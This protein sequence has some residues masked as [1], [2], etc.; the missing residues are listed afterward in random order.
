[1]A[2]MRELEAQRGCEALTEVS[3]V[4]SRPHGLSPAPCSVSLLNGMTTLTLSLFTC[5]LGVL[6]LEGW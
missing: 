5:E 4:E 1:M 3:E 2:G 6:V